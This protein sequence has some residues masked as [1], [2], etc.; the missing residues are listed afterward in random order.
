MKTVQF[1]KPRRPHLLGA[2]IIFCLR[3]VRRPGHQFQKPAVQEQT[4]GL[5]RQLLDVLVE[6]FLR[7]ERQKAALISPSFRIRP[8]ALISGLTVSSQ[9]A[10]LPSWFPSMAK[11][12]VCPGQQVV[13][14]LDDV[15]EL[16]LVFGQQVRFPVKGVSRQDNSQAVRAEQATCRTASMHRWLSS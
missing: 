2:E 9:D 3:L 16:E 13:E 10:S 15:P 12:A 5:I 8:L 7:L 14:A 6:F 11:A 4:S 1:F